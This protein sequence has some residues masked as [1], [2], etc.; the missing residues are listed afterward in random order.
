MIYAIVGDDG[1]VLAFF[2]ES[3]GAVHS[4]GKVEVWS[5]EK[6]ILYLDNKLP[7]K[8]REYKDGERCD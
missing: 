4:R 5:K 2:S 8:V 6:L 7:G 1:Q 3:A